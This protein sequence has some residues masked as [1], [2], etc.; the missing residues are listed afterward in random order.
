MNE[1]DINI[2]IVAATCFIL[3]IVMYNSK[4]S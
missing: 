3:Y 2:N 1:V 4:K